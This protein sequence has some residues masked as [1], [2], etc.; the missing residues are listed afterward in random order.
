MYIDA[1]RTYS[2]IQIIPVFFTTK[3]QIKP[4]ADWRAVDSPKKQ[5]NEFVMFANTANKTNSFFGRIY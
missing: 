1:D 5:T 4:N 2:S 3:G